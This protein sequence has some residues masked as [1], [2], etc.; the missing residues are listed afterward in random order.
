MQRITARSLQ[1]GCAQSRHHLRTPLNRMN[2][3]AYRLPVTTARLLHQ[4]PLNRDIPQ[5]PNPPVPQPTVTPYDGGSGSNRSSGEDRKGSVYA[6][7]ASSPIIQAAVTTAIG[8]IAV[9]VSA[10][11]RMEQLSKRHTILDCIDLQEE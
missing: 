2:Q 4:S 11:D 9:S 5:W 6:E 7:L 8:L 1:S 3:Y 10:D